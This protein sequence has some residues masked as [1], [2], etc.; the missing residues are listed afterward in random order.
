MYARRL[1][2]LPIILAI[3]LAM[4]AG[5]SAADQGE[6]GEAANGTIVSTAVTEDSTGDG[7]ENTPVASRPTLAPTPA[8]ERVTDYVP[9]EST[10]AK[11][12]YLFIEHWSDVSGSVDCEVTIHI[13]FPTYDYEC[14]G[15]C[16]WRWGPGIPDALIARLD[17][18]S[19]QG[20]EQETGPL[21]GFLGS[22]SSMSNVGGGVASGLQAISSLPME[23]PDSEPA[24]TLQNV[25]ADGSVV[26]A[27]GGDA[28][29]L[30]P[31]QSWVQRESAD[32]QWLASLYQG[33][34]NIPDDCTAVMTE[35]LT[36]FG[37]LQRDQLGFDPGLGP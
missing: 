34:E 6:P 36:N 37:L 24:M 20:N 12:V 5:C 31:G 33:E 19:A 32:R 15:P 26:L 17:R 1:G 28:Y 4:A 29:L 25:S 23:I 14:D 11:G 2:I 21:I 30:A 35:R 7:N 18:D 13:D 10:Q 8:V 27:I 16:D 22:G 3:G 9:G